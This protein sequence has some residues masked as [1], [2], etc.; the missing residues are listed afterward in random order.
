M[1]HE[2][3]SNAY[4]YVLDNQFTKLFLLVLQNNFFHFCKVICVFFYK[5]HVLVNNVISTVCAH[6][7]VCLINIGSSKKLKYLAC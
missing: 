3:N 1:I 6:P 5:L 4:L 7:A 2:F